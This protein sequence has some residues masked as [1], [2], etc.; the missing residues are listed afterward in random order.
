MNQNESGGYRANELM[1]SKMRFYS[2]GTVAEN[3][4]LN[5]MDIEVTPVEE[6]TMLDGELTSKVTEYKATATDN[7][8]QTYEGSVK[9]AVTIKATWLRLG[10]SNRMTSP[11]V[12]RGEAVMIFQ[13]GNSEK[14]WWMTIKQDSDL[15]KLETVVWAI[16]ASHGEGDS[17]DPDHTYY[18][19]MSSHTGLVA[20]HTSKANGEPFAYDLQINA[21][22]GKIAVTDDVGNFFE[23]D[24]TNRRIQMKNIDGSH[25]DLD[26]QILTMTTVKQIVQNTESW[27]VNAKTILLN[28]DTDTVDA[29]TNVKQATTLETTLLVEEG[30]TM[31]GGANVQ[32]GSGA[33]F[34]IT[35]GLEVDNVAVSGD[36]NISGGLTVA[37]FANLNGGHTD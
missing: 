36:V 14:F 27:T 17:M 7:L 37:G 26:K 2:M 19:E 11:D 15:R 8:G 25:F 22:E 32:G 20:L 18:F 30:V 31:Q 9:T 4:E 21:K 29:I 3:K 23:L 35:G 16:S 12:R 33:S 28:A 13:F 6:L 5:S 10:D 24:S 1:T 34:Q